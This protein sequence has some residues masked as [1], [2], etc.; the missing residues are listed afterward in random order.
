MIFIS[1]ICVSDSKI[2]DAESL[3]P[4]K[5]LNVKNVHKAQ[6]A[7]RRVSAYR[8]LIF[9]TYQ[10]IKRA[11]HKLLPPA[12]LAKDE[13]GFNLW[14]VK[15]SLLKWISPLFWKDRMMLR[16]RRCEATGQL[17][18]P[19]RHPATEFLSLG[20]PM[21]TL[22]EERARQPLVR[23]PQVQRHQEA[24]KKKLNYVEVV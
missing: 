16:E 21:I 15:R 7:Q 12:C 19:R 1:T 10:D 6:K 2:W 17:G 11:E 23:V 14:Q 4:N 22:V 3:I 13:P 8:A 9:W 5:E 18:A 24:I 20:E